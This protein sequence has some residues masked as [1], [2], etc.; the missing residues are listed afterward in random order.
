M[1]VTVLPA[2]HEI[3]WRNGTA[4]GLHPVQRDGVPELYLRALA[5][6]P[7]IVIDLR[8]LAPGIEQDLAQAAP[9]DRVGIVFYTLRHRFDGAQAFHEAALERGRVDVQ[10]LQLEAVA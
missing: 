4:V 9:R 7:I 8:R 6:T 5:G 2:R 3:L 1:S 10:A